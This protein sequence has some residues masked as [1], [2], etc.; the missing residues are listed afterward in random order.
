MGID[1][2]RARR[3]T[4]HAR[5]EGAAQAIEGQYRALLEAIP[6]LIFHLDGEGR[7]LD[8]VL[9]KGQEPALRPAEFLGRTVGEVMPTD[10]ARRMMHHIDRA[11]Q[12]G[13]AQVLEYRIPVPLPDGNPRDYEARIAAS[14][15]DEVVAIVRD[16]TRSRRTRDAL[17]EGEAKYRQVFEH[18]HDVFYRADVNGAFT[19]ISPSV[20]WW[21]YDAEQLIG[22]Q[23]SHV[24][25]DPQGRLAFL[26]LLLEQGRVIDYEVRLK[27]GDGRLIDASV[28]SHLLRDRDGVVVEIEGIARDITE[29]KRA[30]QAI[31]E[32]E[33]RLRTLVTNAPVVLFAIDREGVFTVVEGRAKSLVGFKPEQDIGRSVFEMYRDVPGV[34][35]AAHRA[36]GGEAFAVTVET[37]D[38]VFEAHV[39]PVRDVDG[40]ITGAV[41]VATDVTD[42]HRAEERLRIQRDLALALSATTDLQDTLRLCLQAA[43]RVSDLDSGCVY[44]GDRSSGALYLAWHEGLG[45]KFV[46]RILRFEAGSDHVRTVMTGKPLYTRYEKLRVRMDEARRREGLRAFAAVPVQHGDEVIA[47]LCVASHSLDDIPPASR[48]ALE[49]IAARIGSAIVRSEADEALRES[50]ERFRRL[51]EGSIDGIVLIKGSEVR[52]ANTALVQMLGYESDEEVLG[53]PFTDFVSEDY[54]ESM[55][56]RRR[57]RNEGRDVPDR[58]E[59]R[60]L[61]KDGS[62][63]DAEISVSTITYRGGWARLG[64]IRDVTERKRAEEALRESEERFRR[65]SEATL[66]GIVIHDGERILDANPQA[67]AMVGYELS[68]LIGMDLFGLLAPGCHDLARQQILSGYGESYEVRGLRKDGTTFPME[69]CGKTASYE[70]RQVRVGVM[71]DI[72]ERK[73]AEE[74][75]Q[76]AREELESRAE[77]AMRRGNPYGLTFRELTVLYLMAAGRADKEIAFQLGISPRTASK[78]VENILQKMGVDSRTEASVHALRECLVGDAH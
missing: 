12:T 49:A 33:E 29:R 40:T 48:A 35:D 27:T 2:R 53:R 21:G 76:A 22:A 28:S 66:D 25:E 18:V 45:D 44:L 14:A 30:E 17:R 9:A 7:F 72:S 51:A 4:Q 41:A 23:V 19:E 6:D 11:L 31:R 68:E 65:L 36:L 58:Y 10:L 37:G 5:A 57:A 1:R 32:S 75:A 24:Y 64:L 78:H 55:E 38:M 67:A 54:R 63:F 13:E 43:I 56:E 34:I 62:E 61:R 8:F 74:A 59:L 69:V 15:K 50:E 77:H 3:P 71:R 73:R 46:E 60:P 16:I 26:S 47:C 70:G 52:F 39:S 20:E 42:R